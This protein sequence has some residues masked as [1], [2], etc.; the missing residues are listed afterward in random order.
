MTSF[1]TNLSRA[2]SPGLYFKKPSLTDPA[3]AVDCDI[4][5]LI[6]R[7]RQTGRFYDSPF[8]QRPRMPLF[9]DFASLPSFEDALAIGN[10]AKDLFMRLPS[11]L[12]ADF[13]NSPAL[14]VSYLTSQ[15]DDARVR[16]PFLFKKA[17]EEKPVELAQSKSLDNTV[18]AQ[19][20][21]G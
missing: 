3:D 4:N 11:A 10:Q 2:K 13:S 18:P 19:P 14:F 16:Y 1:N 8:K 7:Y 6:A 5:V 20:N 21:Q 15:T 12:R 17:V 9:E